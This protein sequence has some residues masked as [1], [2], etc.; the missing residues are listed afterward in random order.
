MEFLNIPSTYYK[1]LREKLKSAK[2]RVKEN[3]DILEVRLAG[4][5]VRWQKEPRVPS[6]LTKTV[7][8][9]LRSR[10]WDTEGNQI[11]SLRSWHLHT[12]GEMTDE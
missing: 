6:C 4:P 8:L 10:H 9:L 5:L 2:I 12:R 1:Q 11:R 7:E 3:M